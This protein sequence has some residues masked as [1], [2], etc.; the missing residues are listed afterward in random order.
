MLVER[1]IDEEP[2]PLSPSDTVAE[3]REI[4]QE[5]QS[6]TLPVVEPTTRKL[7]GQIRLDQLVDL[8][9]DEDEVAV[10]DLPLEGPAA[11]YPH[12][13]VFEAARQMLMHDASYISVIESDQTYQGVVRKKR[14][15]E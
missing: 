10:S 14:V 13:H 2:T 9:S 3:A 11:V 7:T 1:V 12:Q 8:Q 4:M 15:L 6:D 5:W